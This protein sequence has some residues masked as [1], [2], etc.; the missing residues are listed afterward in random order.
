MPKIK[1]T[2]ID[3]EKIIERIEDR[4]ESIDELKKEVLKL[5]KA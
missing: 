1:K 3:Q 2:Y 4:K 5:K